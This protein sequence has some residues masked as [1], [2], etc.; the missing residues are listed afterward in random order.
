M[1]N[2]FFNLIGISL[3]FKIFIIGIMRPPICAVCGKRFFPTGDDSKGGGLIYFVERESDIEWRKHMKEIGGVGHP[4][5]A[6]WFCAEHYPI[7]VKY[8]NLTIDKAWEKINEELKK[9]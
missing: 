8:Q 2:Y 6:E 1:Y 7:A 3:Y 9:K 4:P 5:N